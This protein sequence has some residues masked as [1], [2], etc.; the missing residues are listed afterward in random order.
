MTHEQLQTLLTEAE[1]NLEQARAR[2]RDLESALNTERARAIYFQ[3][4]IDLINRMLN[5]VG[6]DTPT[7]PAPE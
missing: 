5:S 2:I 7:M 4:Q 1:S 6:S 3:G